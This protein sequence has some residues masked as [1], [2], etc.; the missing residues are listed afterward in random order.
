MAIDRQA[1]TLRPSVLSLL[2]QQVASNMK[3]SIADPQTPHPHTR[4]PIDLMARAMLQ[5]LLR[6]AVTLNTTRT[7][8]TTTTNQHSLVMAP[9]GTDL[10]VVLANQLSG[11]CK[12]GGT[13]RSRSRR[14]IHLRGTVGLHRTFRPYLTLFL[15]LLCIFIETSLTAEDGRCLVC[16]CD[17]LSL[18]KRHRCLMACIPTLLP[19]AEYGHESPCSYLALLL[20]YYCCTS[21]CEFPCLF[22]YHHLLTTPRSLS[23]SCLLYA[24]WNGIEGRVLGCQLFGRQDCG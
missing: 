24:H 7:A 21:T 3:T 16:L 9:T 15:L 4:Q 1:A 10:T 14:C 11:T 13:R 17:T 23:K 18:N 8:K 12:P 2:S 19:P 5:S 22:A 6:T 20:F